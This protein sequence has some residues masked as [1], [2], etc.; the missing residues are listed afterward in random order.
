MTKVDTEEADW[1]E[2]TNE[3]V[4]LLDVIAE[5]VGDTE[6]DLP[7]RHISN[8][9][10]KLRDDYE[11]ARLKGKVTARTKEL[12]EKDKQAERY[13]IRKRAKAVGLELLGSGRH[14]KSERDKWMQ[15]LIKLEQE[16]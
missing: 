3:N 2:V 16:I 6:I 8:D 7:E 1:F 15:K 14:T 10:P 13:L 4:E 9:S 12:T 5:Q 11:R